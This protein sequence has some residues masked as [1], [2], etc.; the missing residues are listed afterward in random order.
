MKKTVTVNYAT[1][2]GTAVAGTEYTAASNTLTFTPGIT[3]RN[4]NV[5]IA[6]DTTDEEDK[7]YNVNLS[8]AVNASITDSTGLGTITDD[9]AEPSLSINDVSVE[10][11]VV[12]AQFTVT[13]SPASEKTVTV[14]YATADSTAVAGTEYTAASNTLTFT[15]GITTRNINVTIADDTT[16]EEDKTYNVNLSGAVNASIT[17]STGLG[18]ITDDDAEPSLSINDVSVDEDAV[19]AQFTV[20][21]SPASEKTVTVN[22]ATADGTAAAGTEYTAASNT[23]T[24]TPGITTRNINVTIADDTTDEEDKTYNVNLSGA[25]NGSITGSTGL[26]TITDDDDPP[27]L[28]INDVS[29]D[30]DAVTAQF[31]VTLSPAS[32]QTVTVNYATAD[33][34]AVAGTEFTGIP[35]TP[36]TFNPGTTTRNINVTIAD[37][38]VDEE[39]KTYNVNLSSAVN[40]SITG[41]TGLGTIID[42]DDPPS[43]SIN[44]VSVDEDAVTA[45]FT[46]TLSPASEKTVTVNYATAD[47]T[48]V[49]GTEFTGIPSTPLTFNPGT[50]TRN[51]NVTIADD[52]VDEEDKT[53]NVNL[54]SAVNASITG[55]TGLGTIIDD[56]DPPSLSI[57][58]VSVDEDAVTAQF[59][60]TLSPASGKTVTV[61]YATADDTAIAVNDY[62]NIGSTPL[63]FS[64]GTTTQNINVTINNDTTDENNETYN[65]NLSGAVNATITGSTGLGTITDNDDPPSLSIDDVS[66]A[67]NA[68]TAQFTVTLSPA[69]AKTVTVNH[70]TADDTAVAGTEFTGI[71]STPLTFNPGI[72]TQ[73]INV[74]ITDDTTDEED[75][76]YNVNLSGAANASITG[77]SGL[78]TITDNDNPPDIKFNSTASTTGDETAT[79]RSFDVV[80]AAV[81]EKTITVKVTDTE[82]GSA[83]SGTD[84]NLTIASPETVTFNPGDTT[85][86]VS[87]T[88]IDDTIDEDTGETISFNLSN[89]LNANLV[90]PT[91][92]TVTITDDD[93]TP[94][95]NFSSSTGNGD[96]NV[97][98]VDIA[99][100]LSN[101]TILT[102]VV[103]FTVAAGTADDSGTDFTLANGQVTIGAGTTSAN[104]SFTVNSD[105]LDED[106]EDFQVTLT[107][108][109]SLNATLGS[110]LTHTYT[111]DDDDD[112]PSLSIDNISAGESTGTAQFTVTLSAESGK[113]VTVS[114][115]TA[116]ITASAGNDYTGITSTVLTFNPGDTTKTIDVSILPDTTDEIDETYN[117]NL[118]GAVNASITGS[119]GLGTITD[120]DDLAS[121]SINDVSADEDT[122]NCSIYSYSF[123]CKRKNCC[124]RLCI[125]WKHCNC[126]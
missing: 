64:P 76:T 29:V 44:D 8:G 49:A 57:N 120:D 12:T 19:T 35:S 116:D 17:G 113:T 105:L 122:V 88:P 90:A 77:S 11:D 3:T 117:V 67:E 54:S 74:T 114:H 72:T 93:N 42:D 2:D 7:T 100:T 62:T 110:T 66:V 33:G 75:K 55:L 39:D 80:L 123:S 51:I 99:V 73:N 103:D 56:D 38:S 20:T 71:T 9:D 92:H 70:A 13:L 96:E 82:G 126:R 36:L 4:I 18:T 24:F 81:S 23:L 10:E 32:A 1:A 59:T 84:Y 26:G 112:T 115:E 61:N 22:Y 124:S 97:S 91:A 87:F 107:N 65:V 104:I 21:L 40:A 27:S 5:T 52:S 53:Y 50:T 109:S 37:D 78:G 58:D 25:V 16:D 111:I 102:V 106:N 47:G 46:V 83:V 30:E 14:N 119:T 45:Q 101:A 69:S 95:V 98:P 85:K 89:A 15:P 60:V 79:L 6:D 41:L 43:L 28:S 48:A 63:T 86:S 121:L 34:T 68:G 94:I 118:S 125:L 31:T 108:V